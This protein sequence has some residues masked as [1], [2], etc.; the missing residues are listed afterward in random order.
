MSK[1]TFPLAAI[2]IVIFLV[3]VGVSSDPTSAAPSSQTT[4]EPW[5]GEKYSCTYDDPGGYY[6]NWW[7]GENVEAQADVIG[8]ISYLRKTGGRRDVDLRHLVGNWAYGARVG[9]QGN[10][11]V[12]CHEVQGSNACGLVGYSGPESQSNSTANLLDEGGTKRIG[13]WYQWGDT[14]GSSYWTVGFEYIYGEPSST[15]DTCEPLQSIDVQLVDEGTLDG[16]DPT[17]DRYENLVAG[18]TYYLET[19]G[20][21]WN[22]GS[23]DRYDISISW[24]E[25]ATWEALGADT[26]GVVEAE[27]KTEYSPHTAYKITPD[28]GYLG[29]DIRVN[30]G[31]ADSNFLDNTGSIDYKFSLVTLDK[32]GGES[33]CGTYY[34]MGSLVVEYSEDPAQ[35]FHSA[36]PIGDRE[37]YR[38]LVPHTWQDGSQY[39]SRLMIQNA[40]SYSGW[41][42]LD[43]HPNTVCVEDHNSDNSTE[44]GWTAYYFRADATTNYYDYMAQ[45]LTGDYSDNLGLMDVKIYEASYQP[46][47]APCS[48]KYQTDNTIEGV[49]V[50]ATQANGYRI[51]NAL[52]NPTTLEFEG[53]TPGQWYAF[54]E[55]TTWSGWKDGGGDPQFDWQI[56]QDGS[57]WQDIDTAAA[58]VEQTSYDHHTYYF[59][60]DSSSYRIRVK[61][62]DGSFAN[63]TGSLKVNIK[64]ATLLEQAPDPVEG[65]CPNFQTGAEVATGGFLASQNYETLPD[66]ID[67]QYLY[68]IELDYPGWT[69][70]GVTG[71]NTADLWTGANTPE[72]FAT[73]SGA[74]C[75]EADEDGFPRMFIKGVGENYYLRADGSPGDNEASV[76]YTIREVTWIEEPKSGSCLHDY[77]PSLYVDYP[78]PR[79]DI[80]AQW[81]GGV[82]LNKQGLNYGSYK[83]ITSGGPWKD[84]AMPVSEQRYDVEI[85]FQNGAVNSWQDLSE[86]AECYVPTLDETG[87]MVGAQAFITILEGQ[88][89]MV[90][91]RANNEDGIW[92][93]NTEAMDFRVEYNPMSN[94]NP[95]DPYDD[96][97]PYQSG[98]CDLDCLRP[99]GVSVPAWLEYFRCQ[100]VKRMAFCD[101]HWAV[102]THM[103]QLFQQRE[104]FGSI[105]ELASAF[106]LVRQTVRGFA[107]VEDGGGD[108][109]DVRVSQPENFIFAPED[110]GGA[111]IPLVGDESPWGEGD[112]NILGEGAEFDTTCTN[113]MAAALGARLAGPIC[114]G[115]NAL[116]SL[117]IMSWFQLFWDLVMIISASMYYNN[118][119]V[120]PMQS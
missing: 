90:K 74:L 68:S 75:V 27:C 97:T 70:G 64:A 73:Y 43:A 88:S 30:D 114:F 96:P 80:P 61:D 10:Y 102:I 28:A 95:E 94:P 119:W 4:P 60:A 37:L 52:D 46:S 118:R 13:G 53:F 21:P 51:P 86:A 38:I 87:Q 120:K 8:I 115:F 116:D 42:D 6:D 109:A 3:L 48:T 39:Q 77:N 69:D 105:R 32:K 91:L 79:D 93:D 2:F 55:P 24:D 67:P 16:T 40:L 58:C 17:G 49:I 47:I 63:N 112:I 84:F 81:Q 82:Y 34:S 56:S 72:N 35:S 78:T 23:A 26:S 36:I 25:G 62:G 76:N 71:Q 85:S 100:L 5:I 57:S 9:D 107:W 11:P 14:S 89:G 83:I 101:Y 59:Q 44:D 19:S 31:P 106:G 7:C 99:T 103:R 113:N 1:K 65:T 66:V 108:P 111:S 98:G 110:G 54:E 18:E 104:P 41:Y 50:F 20:G 92:I 12:W 22:D 117:G 33:A 29:F 45:D 15:G